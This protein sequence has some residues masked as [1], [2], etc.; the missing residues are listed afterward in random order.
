MKLTY[1]A[2]AGLLTAAVSCNDQP[3]EDQGREIGKL[4]LSKSHLKPG[5]QVEIAYQRDGDSSEA[6]KAYAYYLVGSNY[7]PVDI[8]LKDS[9]A[10]WMGKLQIPDSVQAV[11]FHFKRGEKWESNDKKRLR[12]RTGR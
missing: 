4:H 10:K 7:Y 2:L 1:L 5:D 6:P 3:E 8:E 9:S 12:R 11:S